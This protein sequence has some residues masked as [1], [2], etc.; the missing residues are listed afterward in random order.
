MGNVAP[1]GSQVVFIDTPL[2]HAAKPSFTLLYNVKTL[3]LYIGAFKLQVRPTQYTAHAQLVAAVGQRHLSTDSD[4]MSTEHVLGGCIKENKT[5]EWSSR[6]LNEDLRG[7][8]L[9]S[10]TDDKSGTKGD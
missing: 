6:T 7:L 2:A 1:T 10:A 3:K 9:E 5:M 8:R 4:P